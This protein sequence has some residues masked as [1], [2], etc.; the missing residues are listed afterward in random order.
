MS[1]AKMIHLSEDYALTADTCNIVLVKARRDVET[2]ELTGTY[3]NLGYYSNVEGVIRGL[4]KDL[5]HSTI[6]EV[7]TLESL[8]ERLEEHISLLHDNVREVVRE[9]RK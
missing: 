3:A 1:K 9:L 7:T 4:Q 6:S 2:N 5:I 8:V